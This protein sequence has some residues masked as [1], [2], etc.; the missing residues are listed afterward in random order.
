[1]PVI[2]L[3][4][5]KHVKISGSDKPEDDGFILPCLPATERFINRSPDNMAAFRRGKDSF[6]ARKLFRRREY[7]RLLDAARF[8]QP[9]MVELGKDAAHSPP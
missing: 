5:S 6:D 2:V 8:Q 3:F 4:I 1:M 9:I 7:R